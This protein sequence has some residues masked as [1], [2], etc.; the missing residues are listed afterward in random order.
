MQEEVKDWVNMWEHNT[1]GAQWA[2]LSDACSNRELRGRN[3]S[4]YFKN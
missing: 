4:N 2:W 3:G 1:G